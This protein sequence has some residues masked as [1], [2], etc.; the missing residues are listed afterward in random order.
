[1]DTQRPAWL[2]PILGIGLYPEDMS[3][4]AKSKLE[5]LS[6][7]ASFVASKLP[8]VGQVGLKKSTADDVYF[9][10]VNEAKP[11]YP[12]YLS[13]DDITGAFD[14]S[15]D[16]FFAYSYPPQDAATAMVIPSRCVRVD[17]PLSENELSYKIKAVKT[18]IS[19]NHITPL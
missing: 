12:Y 7:F 8:V 5:R 6:T 13:A 11:G 1:M 9:P 2:I 16:A 4:N 15:P 3:A 14:T 18:Q 10:V 19:V 17:A